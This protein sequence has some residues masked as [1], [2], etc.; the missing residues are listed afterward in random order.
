MGYI[1]KTVGFAYYQSVQEM[2]FKE[3]VIFQILEERGKS[4]KNVVY[5]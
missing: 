3:L 5:V 1:L 4:R 2:I